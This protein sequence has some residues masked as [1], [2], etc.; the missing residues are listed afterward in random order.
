MEIGSGSNEPILS[1]GE[2]G[3][4]PM[5]SEKEEERICYEL[6]HQ[7]IYRVP[8]REIRHREVSLGFLRKLSTLLPPNNNLTTLHFIA[9]KINDS[10]I[11]C[12]GRGLETNRTITELNLSRNIFGDR[13]MIGFSRSLE[14][15]QTLEQLD[16]SRNEGIGDIS[17]CA[18][19]KTLRQQT[20]A[21]RSLILFECSIGDSGMKCL[22]NSFRRSSTLEIGCMWCG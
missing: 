19:S 18:L 12:L 22:A 14:T 2:D 3:T 15:N 4:A 1:E 11:I 21:I 17:A 5:L 8:K 9:C 16:L 20:C 10:G 13:G 7:D 6:E